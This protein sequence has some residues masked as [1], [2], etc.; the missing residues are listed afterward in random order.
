LPPQL[1]TKNGG[2]LTINPENKDRADFLKCLSHLLDWDCGSLSDGDDDEKMIF[3]ASP[4]DVNRILADLEYKCLEE[5]IIDTVTVEV[6]DGSTGLCLRESEHNTA[7]V[8]TDGCLITSKSFNVTVATFSFNV[9]EKTWDGWLPFGWT[10][11]ASEWGG[12]FA[13]LAAISCCFCSVVR[14]KYKKRRKRRR[15]MKEGKAKKDR[16]KKKKK[17]KSGRFRSSSEWSER[18]KEAGDDDLEE[19]NGGMELPVIAGS[20]GLQQGVR[21]TKKK[22]GLKNIGLKGVQAGLNIGEKGLNKANK[23][24]IGGP[25]VGLAMKGLNVAKG[26]VEEELDDGKGPSKNLPPPPPPAAFSFQPP[27][28]PQQPAGG[29]PPPGAPSPPPL[30]S[31]NN[32][33][34]A[35]QPPP[36]PQQEDQDLKNRPVPPPPPK[37]EIPKWLGHTDDTTGETYFESTDDGRTTWT[38]PKE[39]YKKV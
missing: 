26:M 35:S 11:T 19:G 36:P 17:Q 24:K 23:L 37:K 7:S 27:R 22:G 29:L 33:N 28:P 32:S 25:A 16:K 9:D 20:E 5:D 18:G 13:G 3:V 6:Y 39:G 15:E 34:S 8:R 10:F 14:H 21:D 12:V 4:Y 2:Q 1:S 31:M 38:E 30:L